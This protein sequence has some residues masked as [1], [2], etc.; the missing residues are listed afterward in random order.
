MK[1]AMMILSSTLALTACTATGTKVDQTLLPQCAAGQPCTAIVQQIGKPPTRATLR[2]DGTRQLIYTYTQAQVNPV[3]FVPI[4]GGLLSPGRRPKI[5]RPSSN[6]TAPGTSLPTPI[7]K[8]RTPPGPGS[9]PEA[10]NERHVDIRATGCG[11][12][13]DFPGAASKPMS[14]VTACRAIWR[15]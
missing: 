9:S 7:P 14:S 8:A 1:R 6:A 10:N 4:V 12:G 3:N 2:E 5:R 13:I 11:Y 15:V